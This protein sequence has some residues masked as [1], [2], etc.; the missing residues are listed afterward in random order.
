MNRNKS[1]IRPMAFFV[2][3]V[4]GMFESNSTFQSEN[5]ITMPTMIE[6]DINVLW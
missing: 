2:V 1:A 5:E 3:M 6:I 4:R